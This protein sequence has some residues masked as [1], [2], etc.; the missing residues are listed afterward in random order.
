MQVTA[1]TCL[2]EWC[3]GDHS[4]AVACPLGLTE[5]QREDKVSIGVSFVIGGRYEMISARIRLWELHWMPEML[6]KDFSSLFSAS[7]VGNHWSW[8]LSHSIL[9]EPFTPAPAVG[10]SVVD[11]PQVWMFLA[12]AK[13]CRSGQTPSWRFPAQICPAQVRGDQTNHSNC[14]RTHTFEWVLSRV[15]NKVMCML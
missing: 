14:S 5:M 13:Q 12:G 7:G 11:L 3:H 15:C 4:Q 1:C 2:W 10:R 9:W 8:Q 6:K